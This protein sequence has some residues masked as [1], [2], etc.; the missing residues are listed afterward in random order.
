MKK[1]V[2]GTL[3]SMTQQE[4]DQYEAVKLEIEADVSASE[5]YQNRANA[6][7]SIKDQLDKIYHEGLDAWKSEIKA[8]KDA[9]PKP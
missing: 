7:P 4:I 3:V 1:M 5:W 2:N 9:H 8:I 6:Y